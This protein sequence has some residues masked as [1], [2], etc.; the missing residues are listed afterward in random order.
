MVLG[1]AV[2]YLQYLRSGLHWSVPRLINQSPV[3]FS[4]SEQS[5]KTCQADVAITDVPPFGD[6]T[7]ELT[8]L[9]A[10]A[11]HLPEVHALSVTAGRA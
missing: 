7:S 4:Y 8:V 1:L 5:P 11:V 9:A 6:F 10:F 3:L 2:I